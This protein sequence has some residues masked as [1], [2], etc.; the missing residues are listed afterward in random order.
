VV[1]LNLENAPILNKIL[2]L[3]H[4]VIQQCVKRHLFQIFSQVP[5]VMS[6]TQ[7]WSV[8]LND[9]HLSW[10]MRRFEINKMAAHTLL[11]NFMQKNMKRF[12]WKHI[13]TSGMRTESFPTP[14]SPNQIMSPWFYSLHTKT[15]WRGSHQQREW[16]DKG[17]MEQTQISR[18]VL[19]TQTGITMWH[20]TQ[21][22]RTTGY[23]RLQRQSQLCDSHQCLSPQWAQQILSSSTPTILFYCFKVLLF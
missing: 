13:Q 18:S 11:N 16:W 1:R 15:Y 12:I 5:H 21:A 20:T 2:F 23:Y 19:K 9:T 7:K 22:A 3:L 4:K 14:T 8:A 17:W 10:S 6:A